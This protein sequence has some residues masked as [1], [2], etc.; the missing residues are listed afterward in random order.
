[1][2]GILDW[3]VEV[4]RGVQTLASPAMTGLMKG[5]SLL[6][7]EWFYLLIL[8]I[9]YWCIDRKRGTRLGVLVLFSA[10][11][12]GWLKLVFAQPRPYDLDP[13]VGLAKEPTFGLPSGHAQGSTVFWGILSPLF[14]RPWGLVLA[15]L[16]PLVVGLSR[17]YLGVHFPTDVFAGWFIGGLIVLLDALFG[18]KAAAALEKLHSRYIILGAALIALG[19]N[20]L[21]K[22][23]SSAAGVFL[24]AIVG[25]VYAGRSL[26]FQ[27][28]GSLGKK[29]LRYLIGLAVTAAIYLGFKAL[30]PGQGSELYALFR[31]LRYGLIGLWVSFGAPWAFIKLGLMEGR[32]NGRTAEKA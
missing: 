12:N 32:D 7:T 4:V 19:M 31:F 22:G 6:G 29:A 17:V 14:R 24:G 11:L 20:Y 5:I 23:D 2:Q 16:M 3:G 9:V 10:F 21:N 26:D 15:I 30:F 27:V 25:F 28:S 1:M 8:P 13:A 18:D